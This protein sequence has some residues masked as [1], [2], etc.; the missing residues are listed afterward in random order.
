MEDFLD[1]LS[2]VPDNCFDLVNDDYQYG[3]KWDIYTKNNVPDIDK[4]K[5]VLIGIEEDRQAIINKGSA[6]SPNE[7]RKFLYSFFPFISKYEVADIGN[8]QQGNT[9]KDTYFAIQSIGEYL[10][11]NDK[12]VILLGGS[13]DLAYAQFLMYEKL[14]RIINICNV[15]AYVDF[16]REIN[17]EISNKNYIGKIILKEPNYLF[18]YSHIAYQSYFVGAH[19]IQFMDDLYFEYYRLGSVRS[20]V[21]ETEPV[22]RNSD[23]MFFDFSAIKRNDGGIVEHFSPNGIS[24]EEA[25]Q[26][27]WYA[28]MNDKL[29]SVGLYEINASIDKTKVSVHLAAQMIWSF[30]EGFYNRK[31]DIPIK[32]HPD[33]E[34][35]S[36][37]LHN[38]KYN[39]NFIRS[40]KT[41][42]WWMEVPYPPHLVQNYERHTMVP[43]TEKDYLTAQS[44]ELPEKWWQT[45]IRISNL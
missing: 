13:N 41:G 35:F 26:I 23:A 6:Q 1:F 43:C 40:H 29:T 10:L 11:K 25:C 2:P 20:K 12:V 32:N 34:T 45:Y 15:D 3:N 21:D 28:G 22:I 31:N 14:E 17:E 4:A 16:S 24:A 19:N 36:V 38:G 9:I 30:I 37:A 42:R 44:D 27:M 7:V 18:N 39:I 8:I 5:I 33:Y